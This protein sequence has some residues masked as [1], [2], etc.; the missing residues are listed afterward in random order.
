MLNKKYLIASG[1]S[2]T[3][4]H[5]IGPDASWSKYFAINNDLE[6]INLAKGGLGND[7]ITQ[8][9][10]NYAT[11]NPEIAKDSLFIIQLSECLR[12][13]ICWDTLQDD[14]IKSFYWHISPLQFYKNPTIREREYDFD[15]FNHLDESF[16]LYKFLYDNR[17]QLSQLYTN[18]T[19]SL[20][21]TYN[22]IIN[23]VNF[24]KA[25]NY[26]YLIFD[27]INNHIPVESNGVWYL[28]STVGAP[29]FKIEVDT[30]NEMENRFKTDDGLYEDSLY[31]KSSHSP[32]IHYKIIELLME[33][34]FYYNEMTLNDLLYKDEK[35][36]K[37]NDNHPNILGS[38]VWAEHLQP[39]AEN[40]F[41][42]IN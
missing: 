37:G 31:F 29:I 11:C 1:C 3:G 4:G 14:D 42:K 38:K 15:D 21:K 22:N 26:P 28:K 10:I 17:Y 30:K 12:F 13:L 5:G 32:S 16:K 23:F 19:F 33:N 41:G 8:N 6:L 20:L 34:P 18:I 7:L 40:L 35:Y 39:I 25:N 27:G 9:T 36:H 24:C 2:F